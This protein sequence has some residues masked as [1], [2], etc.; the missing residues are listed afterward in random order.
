MDT[1]SRLRIE[2]AL[3][4]VDVCLD[5]EDLE[6]LFAIMQTELAKAEPRHSL[7]SALEHRLMR[8]IAILPQ[9]MDIKHGG[10]AILASLRQA[11]VNRGQPR[12]GIWASHIH[13]Q[14]FDPLFKMTVFAEELS[15]MEPAPLLAQTCGMLACMKRHFQGTNSSSVFDFRHIFQKEDGAQRFM[16]EALPQLSEQWTGMKEIDAKDW[17]DIFPHVR[18]FEQQT[19]FHEQFAKLGARQDWVNAMGRIPRQTHQM[20]FIWKQRNIVSKLYVCVLGAISLEITRSWLSIS[21]GGVEALSDVPFRLSP[22]AMPTCLQRYYSRVVT[23]RCECVGRPYPGDERP[24]DAPPMYDVMRKVPVVINDSGS[25]ISAPKHTLVLTPKHKTDAE[26]QEVIDHQM[27]YCS[28]EQPELIVASG[29]RTFRCKGCGMDLPSRGYS[30]KVWK[31]CHAAASYEPTCLGCK[32]RAVQE[33]MQTVLDAGFHRSLVEF[34]MSSMSGPLTTE[35][36]LE[37]VLEK[38]RAEEE[39]YI[40]FFP[41]SKNRLLSLRPCCRQAICS[42]CDRACHSG[43]QG[44]VFCRSTGSACA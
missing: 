30:K 8:S 6:S 33:V 26:K 34:V 40:C 3:R 14:D 5:A 17:S 27:T 19:L 35:T 15:D 9:N 22:S 1:T 7:Q 38:Q 32:K 21:A 4:A 23:A 36:L 39:C 12:D 24:W 31:L 25:L 29:Q 43:S 2:L 42:K 11:T 28:F 10:D 44:C 37:L 18:V 16:N 20:I 41:F 13:T